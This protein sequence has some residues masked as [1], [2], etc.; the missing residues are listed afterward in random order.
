[1]R[2]SCG[3]LPSTTSCVAFALPR[4]TRYFI[5]VPKLLRVYFRKDRRLLGK[6]SQCAADALKTLFRAACKGP[7]AVPGIILAIQTYGTW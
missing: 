1:M 5:T 4:H 3:T 7:R 2:D 6:L